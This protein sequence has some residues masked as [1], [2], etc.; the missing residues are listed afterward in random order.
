MKN[1]TYDIWIPYMEY[2]KNECDIEL[3]DGTI[4]KHVYPNAGK[5]MECCGKKRKEYH[6]SEV[7]K[8]MYIPYYLLDICEK[9][10]DINK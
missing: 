10:C 8:I 9:E 5:F 3:K 2:E 6:E 1:I 7:A 4:I